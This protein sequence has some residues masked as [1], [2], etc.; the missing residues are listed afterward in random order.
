VQERADA[1]VG[2]AVDLMDG[3]RDGTVQRPA[4]HYQLDELECGDLGIGDG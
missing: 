2:E 3:H 1:G 4:G